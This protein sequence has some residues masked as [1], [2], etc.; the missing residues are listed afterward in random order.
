MA[1]TYEP[2]RVARRVAVAAL[3]FDTLASD[4]GPSTT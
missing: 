2:P 1:R 3:G 4:V